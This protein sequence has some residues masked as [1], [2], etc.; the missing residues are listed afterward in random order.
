MSATTVATATTTTTTASSSQV[1]KDKGQTRTPSIRSTYET[2]IVLL[3]LAYRW[4]ISL[5]PHSGMLCYFYPHH[6]PS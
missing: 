4:A 2:T 5:Y 1:I 3:T 6:T